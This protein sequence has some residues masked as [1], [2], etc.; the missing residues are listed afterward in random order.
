MN[1]WYEGQLITHNMIS[2]CLPLDV[3][4]DQRIKEWFGENTVILDKSLEYFTKNYATTCFCMTR[5]PWFRC[6]Q[7]RSFGERFQKLVLKQVLLLIVY[8]IYVNFMFFFHRKREV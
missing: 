3:G 7:L 5:F 1:L 4:P 8:A 2:L 6:K